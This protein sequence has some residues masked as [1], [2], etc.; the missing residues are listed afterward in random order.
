MRY[1]ED[2]LG[3]MP[4]KDKEESKRVQEKTSDHETGLTSVKEER[5][6]TNWKEGPQTAAQI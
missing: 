2:L 3:A 6:G 5:K 4:I 1:A